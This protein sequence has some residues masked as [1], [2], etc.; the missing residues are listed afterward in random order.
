MTLVVTSFVLIGW[1]DPSFGGRFGNWIWGILRGSLVAVA[2]SGA[3]LAVDIALLRA[4]VCKPPTGRRAWATALALP[5]LVFAVYLASPPNDNELGLS[6]FLSI[7]TPIVVLA[8]L[9][10]FLVGKNAEAD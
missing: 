5:F 1:T 2:M 9:L 10:R 8:L 6:F 4:D 7:L 3:L